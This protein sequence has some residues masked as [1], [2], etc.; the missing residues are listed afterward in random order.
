[1][2]KKVNQEPPAYLGLTMALVG[3]VFGLLLLRLTTNYGWGESAAAS[4]VIC[5]AVYLGSYIRARRRRP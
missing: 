2:K 5:V 1:M 3:F 4:G